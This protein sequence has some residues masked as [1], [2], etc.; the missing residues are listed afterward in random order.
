MMRERA[1]P[2][3][4]LSP[5]S[6]LP[7]RIVEYGP[8]TDEQLANFVSTMVNAAAGQLGVATGLSPRMAGLMLEANP[9]AK[10]GWLRRHRELQEA[11]WR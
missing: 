10:Q 2:V 6:S 8:P 1:A 4:R 9:E 3:Q 5:P 11:A 7:R